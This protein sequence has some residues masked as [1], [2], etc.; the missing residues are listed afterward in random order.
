[1]PRNKPVSVERAYVHDPSILRGRYP[2]PGGCFFTGTHP[3]LP[4]KNYKLSLANSCEPTCKSRLETGFNPANT[5]VTAQFFFSPYVTRC[6]LP[7]RPSPR[8][9]FSVSDCADCSTS[10]SALLCR[11]FGQSSSVRDF[12]RR[13]RFSLDFHDARSCL[14]GPWR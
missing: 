4:I 1:M 12:R 7:P 3:F 5:P 9:C 14:P 8:P 11:C 10:K 6:T 2:R 13:S